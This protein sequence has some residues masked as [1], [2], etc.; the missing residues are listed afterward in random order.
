[1][2]RHISD[3]PRM[4]NTIRLRE[5]TR[6]ERQ[7]GMHPAIGSLHERPL[8]RDDKGRKTVEYLR[9]ERGRTA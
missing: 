1:M 5:F 8:S 2:S 4:A 7:A 6:Q 3:Q 9:I